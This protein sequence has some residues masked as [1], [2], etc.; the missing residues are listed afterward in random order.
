MLSIIFLVA[1]VW[2]S[3]KMFVF[4]MKAAWGIAKILCT[5]L[6]FPVFLVGLVCVGLLYLAILIL[7]IIGVVV[8][9][10]EAVKA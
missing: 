6:L 1:L 3:W 2:V 8:L 7:V 10:G 5:V 9:I 4:G